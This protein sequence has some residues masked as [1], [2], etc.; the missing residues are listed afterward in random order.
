M[1]IKL[2]SYVLWFKYINIEYLDLLLEIFIY[3]FIVMLFLV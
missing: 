1:L 3:S 2:Q